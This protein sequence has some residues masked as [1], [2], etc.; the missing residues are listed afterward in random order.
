MFLQE[1]RVDKLNTDSREG[2]AWLFVFLAAT[3][4]KGEA[5]VIHWFQSETSLADA[6]KSCI[7]ISTIQY[8]YIFGTQL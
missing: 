7:H 3:L 4:G 5:R 1:P 8:I 2:F 6:I